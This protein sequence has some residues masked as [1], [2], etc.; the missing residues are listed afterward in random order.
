MLEAPESDSV[1]HRFSNADKGNQF[2]RQC[3]FFEQYKIDYGYSKV[4]SY[5][6]FKLTKS[7][8]SAEKT[9]LPSA[10]F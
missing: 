5:S 10:N 8:L 2:C 3:N 1:K 6:Q 9:G 4:V 7:F